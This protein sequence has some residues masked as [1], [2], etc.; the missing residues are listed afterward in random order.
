MASPQI[1]HFVCYSE[2]GGRGRRRGEAEGGGG[3]KK[4]K[5]QRKRERACS[6]IVSRSI[7]IEVIKAVTGFLV[8]GE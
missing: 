8:G 2:N 4:V 1:T 3:I 5:K 7:G 6:I